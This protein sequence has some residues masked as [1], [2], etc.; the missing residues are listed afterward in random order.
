MV[1]L[2]NLQD[3]V[4]LC[5]AITP[6]NNVKLST[7]YFDIKIV[8]GL[9]VKVG[10]IIKGHGTCSLGESKNSQYTIHALLRCTS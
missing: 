1:I 3:L 4:L 5:L 6:Y 10:P 7:K 2:S 8:D 9:I